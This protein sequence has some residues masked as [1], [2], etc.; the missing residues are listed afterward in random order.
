MRKLTFEISQG[1]TV[2]L[3]EIRFGPEKVAPD[4]SRPKKSRH[5]LM[6]WMSMKLPDNFQIQEHSWPCMFHINIV[7]F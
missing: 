6:H 2:R 5:F 3:N 4:I 7:V 1:T